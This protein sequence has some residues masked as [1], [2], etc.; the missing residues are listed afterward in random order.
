MLLIHGCCYMLSCFL[1]WGFFVFF[2][3]VSPS[4]MYCCWVFFV[5][6]YWSIYFFI[7]CSLLF[8]EKIV[9]VAWQRH[10]NANYFASYDPAK[11][12]KKEDAEWCSDKMRRVGCVICWVMSSFSHFLP[13]PRTIKYFLYIHIEWKNYILSILY[14]K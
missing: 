5:N 13:N 9:G 14:S 7:P 10:L 11:K 8:W 3:Y 12:R 6:F 1:A 4:I 2:G